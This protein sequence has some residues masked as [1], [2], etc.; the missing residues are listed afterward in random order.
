MQLEE[1]RIVTSLKMKPGYLFKIGERIGSG[2]KVI[3]QMGS[4]VE[5]GV[6]V[7]FLRCI[8]YSDTSIVP[9]KELYLVIK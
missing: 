4:H 5:V 2:G 3:S 8:D 1:L 9:S 6:Y 7:K